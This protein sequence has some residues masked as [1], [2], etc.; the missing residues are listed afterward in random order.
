M[1]RVPRTFFKTREKGPAVTDVRRKHFSSMTQRS[2]KKP[3]TRRWLHIRNR[4]EMG[5]HN[6]R[7]S[8]QYARL[9]SRCSRLI[10]WRKDTGGRIC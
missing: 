5:V 3:H 2:G 6:D 9:L 10:I 1:N 7:S 4:I 8:A